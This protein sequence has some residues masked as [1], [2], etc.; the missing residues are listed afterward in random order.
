MVR[1]VPAAYRIYITYCLFIHV[2]L[3]PKTL[4]LR[5]LLLDLRPEIVDTPGDEHPGGPHN[6][7]TLLREGSVH[8]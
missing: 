1:S 5:Q 7:G 3:V 2:G 6:P 4:P 8:L